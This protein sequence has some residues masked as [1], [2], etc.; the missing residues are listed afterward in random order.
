MA[1]DEAEE[2]EIQGKPLTCQVCG[3][4]RFHSRTAQLNTA[5]A[6]FFG[7]DWANRSAFCYVC[8]ACGYIHWFLPPTS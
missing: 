3:R 4:S 2:I 6:T 8:E 1:K 5:T 7:F